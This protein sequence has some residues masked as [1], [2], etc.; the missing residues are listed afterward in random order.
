MVWPYARV[1]CVGVFSGALSVTANAVEFDYSYG[2][3][4]E[5]SDNVRLSSVDS[6]DELERSALVGVSFVEET[7]TV[8][9]DISTM[10]QHNNYRDETFP[11]ENW[12]YLNGDVNLTLRPRTFFW[13]IEDIFSQQE[14]DVFAPETPDNL[15]NTNFFSTGP[16]LVFRIN[17]ANQVEVGARV[18]DFRYDQVNTDS[19]RASLDAAWVYRLY[20]GSS[21][22]MNYGFEK[23]EFDELQDSD[24][25]RQNVFIRYT[26]QYSRSMFEMDAGYSYVDR[27]S[28]DTLNGLLG[29]LQWRNQFRDQSHFE[30][31]LSSQYTDTGQ[32]LITYDPISMSNSQINGDIFYDK[33]VEATY[34]LSYQ[35][36]TYEVLMLFRDED[37]E[38]LA[39]DRR[40]K[41][42]R[43]NYGHVYSTTLSMNA[44][45]EFRTH[46]NID[47]GQTDDRTSA[48][49]SGVYRL[50]RD[51]TFQLQYNYLEQKSDVSTSNYKENRV[52]LSFYYGRNPRSYR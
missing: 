18:S 27:E 14:L 39:R 25:D 13:S 34:H 32:D 28:G 46:D 2:V 15:I 30:L 23:A 33:R 21:L 40:I 8:E 6:Q 48:V 51:Y 11:D 19:Q 10:L 7:S 1:A 36:S 24:F 17:P 35:S 52:M 5:Y 29:R 43:L 38:I 26:S 50:S 16:D 22:S 9:A 47:V 41:G 20:R 49:L 4:M 12:F 45:V 31:E 37:Y 44:Q 42:I 3:E